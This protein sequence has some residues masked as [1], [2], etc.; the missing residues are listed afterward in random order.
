MNNLIQL[1]SI[2]SDEWLAQNPLLP[3]VF[4]TK[5]NQGTYA[6]ECYG[7]GGCNGIND[8]LMSDGSILTCRP[9]ELPKPKNGR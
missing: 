8:Y 5:A 7:Y 2:P 9:S 3:A 6:V 4:V 1:N